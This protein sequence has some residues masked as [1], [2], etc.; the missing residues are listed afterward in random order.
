MRVV[1]KPRY[2]NWHHVHGTGCTHNSLHPMS[3]CSRLRKFKKI[4][5]FRLVG[6]L[7]W[8]DPEQCLVLEREPCPRARPSKC[9]RPEQIQPVGSGTP[10]SGTMCPILYRNEMSVSS[11]ACP[12]LLQ[13]GFRGGAPLPHVDGTPMLR[14][15]AALR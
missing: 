7:A 8:I 1:E 14:G 2:L 15:S 3:N 12:A 10:A 13:G 4:Y 9:D 6:E 5:S 11:G